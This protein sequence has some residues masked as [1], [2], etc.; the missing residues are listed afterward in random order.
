MSP[1][2]SCFLTSFNLTFPPSVYPP[3]LLTVFPRIVVHA[4]INKTALFF[5][6]KY[7]RRSPLKI[8]EIRGPC[9]IVT[10]SKKIASLI[11]FFALKNRAIS[12]ISA[13]TTMRGNTVMRYTNVD[14]VIIK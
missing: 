10:S 14:I 9:I 5:R 13:C 1:V 3:I 11:K 2:V 12:Y 7:D 8:L 6:S 4:L